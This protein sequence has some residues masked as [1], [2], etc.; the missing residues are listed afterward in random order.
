MEQESSMKSF[1]I[2]LLITKSFTSYFTLH[3]KFCCTTNSCSPSIHAVAHTI[4]RKYGVMFSYFI[5]FIWTFDFCSPWHIIEW[6]ALENA[7]FSVIQLQFGRGRVNTLFV[8]WRIYSIRKHITF[9]YCKL[10]V[11]VS[12]EGEWNKQKFLF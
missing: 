4:T 10:C 3:R 12:C 6:K 9:G 5:F 8:K 2:N 11:R 1:A 7:S